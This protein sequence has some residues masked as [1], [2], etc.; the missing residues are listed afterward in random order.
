[1]PCRNTMIRAVLA[2]V[3]VP[4]N[5][6]LLASC[7]SVPFFYFSDRAGTATIT[8]LSSGEKREHQLCFLGLP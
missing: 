5:F 8:I 3:G 1:M 2:L 4:I 7:F 6:V